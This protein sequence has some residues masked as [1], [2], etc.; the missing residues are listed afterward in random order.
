MTTTTTP[1]QV[2]LN[3]KYRIKE[4]LHNGK[5]TDVWLAED[6]TS[7]KQV[8]IKIAHTEQGLRSLMREGQIAAHYSQIRHIVPARVEKDETIKTCLVMDYMAGGSLQHL[9]REHESQHKVMPWDDAI[10]II[11][12]LASILSHLHHFGCIHRDIHPGNVL[13]EKT[14]RS[15]TH[16]YLSDF[17]VAISP[18]LSESDATQRLGNQFYRAPEAKP[19]ASDKPSGDVYML[20][21]MLIHMLSGR[22]PSADIQ[23]VQDIIPP[24]VPA[25][26]RELT[27]RCVDSD[28]DQRPNCKAIVATI[29]QKKAQLK[30]PG[31]HPIDIIYIPDGKFL[32]GSNRKQDTS[33]FPNE[34]E[35]HECDIPEYFISRAPITV[36]QFEA[37]IQATGYQT[38][39]ERRGFCHLS[40]W[41]EKQAAGL[42][43]RIPPTP[44]DHPVT[45]VSWIDATEFCVWA[46]KVTGHV[47]RL[48]SEAEWEKAARGTD[49]RLYPWGNTHPDSKYCN[50]GYSTNRTTP[51]LMTAGTTTPVGSYSPM[52]DS[53]FGCVDMAGNVWEWT[54][55]LYKPYPYK[56]NTNTQDALDDKHN[57]VVR[58]GAFFSQ[59]KYLRVATR[60]EM[61]PNRA[62]HGI[63]FRV[64]VLI[65]GD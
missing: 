60:R 26:V 28:P 39:A 8:V 6:T 63:G 43:W 65:K 30:L 58:G 52:G 57:R 56:H 31:T 33:A 42:N 15:P 37:F 51:G 35:Q 64:V 38:T 40:W 23:S 19:G 7:P 47:V 17:G 9:L 49:G 4:Q 41:G 11:R 20:G 16:I 59:A 12:K 45:R 53:P 1:G 34:A 50:F 24:T 29:L 5:N 62:F 13:F 10:E 18:T 25:W 54:N 44:P 3:D 27:L 36:A 32:L 61:E 46:S 22:M 14:D 2:I 55:S 48:P 21:Q